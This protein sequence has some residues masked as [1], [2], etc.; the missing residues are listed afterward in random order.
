[1]NTSSFHDPAVFKSVPLSQFLR[2]LHRNSTED[3]RNSAL[4]TIRQD[5]TNSGYTTQQLSVAETKAREKFNQEHSAQQQA[6]SPIILSTLFFKDAH[7]LR[8]LL[9]NLT[10]DMKL[11]TGDINLKPLLAIKKG[12]NIGEQVSKHRNSSQPH[13]QDLS[14]QKC[15]SARC[16]SCILFTD[17]I[18]EVEAGGFSH[19]GPGNVNCKSR[20]TIYLAQCSICRN[21]QGSY[22][23]QSQQPLH[24]RINGHR[25]DFYKQPHLSALAY[26][27]AQQ[28]GA[29]LHL[30]DFTLTIL[31]QTSP[32]NLDRLENYYMNKFR[33]RTLGLNRSNI[34][35]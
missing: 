32:T 34:L 23:G 27:S 19:T 12:P 4:H 15:L 5:L 25:H 1:M 28:H 17:N 9:H 13:N 10:E 16:K 29:L 30:E 31:A 24:K 7:K 20:N 21:S 22:T 35:S 8:S 2:V 26:H 18:S 14:T 11:A 3:C 33:C 6:C